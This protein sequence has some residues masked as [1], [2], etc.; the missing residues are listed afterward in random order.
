MS[1]LKKSAHYRLLQLTEKDKQN[2]FALAVGPIWL[3][4][5]DMADYNPLAEANGNEKYLFM[6]A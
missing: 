5:I 3:K 4:P 2:L 1:I 6:P